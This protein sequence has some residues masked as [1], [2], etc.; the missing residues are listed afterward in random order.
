MFLASSLRIKDFTQQICVQIQFYISVI[1]VWF[2]NLFLLQRKTLFLVMTF[3]R[4]ESKTIALRV[5]RRKLTVGGDKF[6][7]EARRS[8]GPI[9]ECL[10]RRRKKTEINEGEDKVLL[11]K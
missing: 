6:I 9:L 10:E 11:K 1:D 7:A 8:C 5:G 4:K 3:I 2:K